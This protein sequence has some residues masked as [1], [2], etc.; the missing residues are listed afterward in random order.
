MERK[1]KKLAER[2]VYFERTFNVTEP[3]YNTL[4][5]EGLAARIREVG[6]ASTIMATDFG[7]PDS[8]SPAEGL[9]TYV[10]G[11]LAHGLSADEI[12]Q[13]VSTHARTLLGI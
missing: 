13:M 3:R 11:M 1:Q 2:G 10:A 5:V 12:K 9:E 6:P 4:T 8:L 7:Q